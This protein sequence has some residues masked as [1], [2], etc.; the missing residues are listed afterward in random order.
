MAV[1]GIYQ[2]NAA[3]PKNKL[4]LKGGNCNSD[5]PSPRRHQKVKTMPFVGL[6]IHVVIAIFCAIHAVRSR[7]QMYWLFILFA[8]PLL[9][10]LVYIFAVYLPRSRFERSAMKAVSAAVKIMDPKREVREARL[11]F[12]EAPTAQ[13]QMDLAGALLEVG[14]AEAAAQHYE[15]CLKGPFA[16][17]PEIRFGAGRACVECERY[18]DA[19]RY[20]EPLCEELPDFRSEA[21]ALLLARALAATSRAP[22]VSQAF[23][24][25]VARFDTYEAK[26]E[27]AIWAYAQGDTATSER[28]HA[29]LEKIAKRWNPMSR[30]LNGPVVRRL[31]TARSVRQCF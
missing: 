3:R 22:E 2:T 11:A 15:A 7:Q 30:A 21:V 1:W 10:S 8:F 19:L 6:Q 17:D 25:A 28:L 20:L 14:E 12:E 4:N 31:E 16:A 24:S 13:N 23:E 29:D 26:A 27:Y 18:A 5:L 9:G